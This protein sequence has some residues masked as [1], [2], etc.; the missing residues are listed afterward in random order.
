MTAPRVMQSFGTPRQTTNPYIVML[1]SALADEPGIEHLRFSWRTALTERYDVF[2]VH[3]GDTLLAGRHWWTRAGK[4]AAFA[5]L[6]ARLAALRIPVVRTVH[7]ASAFAGGRMDTALVRRLDARTAVEIVLTDTT[8]RTSA[9]TLPRELVPHGHYVTWFADMPQ[10]EPIPH[11]WGFVGL[12]KPYKGIEELLSA[13]T[14]AIDDG[15]DLTLH[16][17]GR[18]TDPDLTRAITAAVGP[19]LSADLRYISEAEF[20]ATVTESSAIVLPYR[21]MLNSGA[22]LAA[23]SLAR[24][25]LMPNNETNRALA[26]E[27]GPHWVELFD[28]APTAEDLR[29]LLERPLPSGRPDLTARDWTH[30]AAGHLNAYRRALR[31]A[32]IEKVS[33]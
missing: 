20:A 16:I 26:A 12:I 27:V 11:R 33:R 6:L 18:S 2:H 29:A 22:A 25:V 19:R 8:P 10:H 15:A 3:W 21:D 23:L 17:A 7:N 30:T 9:H 13:F 4:R 32:Q 1:D 28:T 31:A 24:P 14:E 5:L